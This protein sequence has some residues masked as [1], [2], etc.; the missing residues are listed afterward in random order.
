M[1][2]DIKES[3]YALL[4]ITSSTFRNNEF[5]PVRYTCDG[6]N[7]SPPIDIEYIPDSARYM[8][9]IVDDP[10]ALIGTWVHWVT[11]NIPVTHHIGENEAKG[12]QGMND[13]GR[14][15]YCG[16]CPP[17]GT[18]RYCF[19]VYI[20]DTRLDLPESATK[21]VLEKAMISHILAYGELVGFYKRK[22]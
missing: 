12:V 21:Y 9:I 11:W 7:V 2:Y 1:K 5:I 8:A 19:K 3:K 10:D 17:S 18:H 6:T 14:H 15:V 20:L 22:K 13:F 16:P 4:K